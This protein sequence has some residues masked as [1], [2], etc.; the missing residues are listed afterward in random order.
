MTVSVLVVIAA[1]SLVISLSSRHESGIKGVVR[2]AAEVTSCRL[3]PVTAAVYVMLDRVVFKPF[4]PPVE[5]YKHLV[6]DNSGHFQVALPPGTYW[7]AAERQDN[8]AFASDEFA[9][10]IVQAG[11]M[12]D[13]TI[14]LDLHSPQ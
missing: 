10:V 9:K 14:D 6:T 4:G 7:I 13:I 8:S 3:T 12:T 1:L 11:T 2:C 5:P